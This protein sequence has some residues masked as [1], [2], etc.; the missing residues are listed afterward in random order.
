MRRMF[1]GVLVVAFL[2]SPAAMPKEKPRTE[3]LPLF[4]D[5][6]FRF[7]QVQTICLA[8][9]LDLRSDKTAPLFLSE[10]GPGINFSHTPSANQETA[11]VLNKIGY[12]TTECN[13]VSATI[14]D[15]KTPLDTWLRNLDF[16]QSNWLFVLAVE[17]LRTV[18]SFWG[19]TGG[20]VGA[21][22]V[23][24]GF[25]FE[26]RG[27]AVRLVWRDRAVGTIPEDLVGGR[28]KEQEAGESAITVDNAIDHILA[29]F[30]RR[31]GRPYLLFAVDEENFG[32]TCDVVWIALQDAFSSDSKKYKV[33]FIDPS[34]KMAFYTIRH[35]SFNG[36]VENK[37]HVV[38]KVRG[39]G[40]AM[41]VTQSYNMKRTD[42]WNDLT[43]RMLAALA[44]Q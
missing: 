11:A 41:Q 37:N 32:A 24:S 28:K 12:Q 1:L 34:D 6:E 44:K 43:K 10:R 21:R 7:S 33:E 23:V 26:K 42:D 8:P 29:E 22:A 25:L 14:N 3:P 4:M 9:A 27:D 38:L 30:E 40:C 20:A 36:P 15:L 19:P 35:G 16:G 5:P 13:P 39:D 18:T 17:D 2:W 31:K